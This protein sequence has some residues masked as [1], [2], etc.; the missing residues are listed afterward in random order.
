M[1]S[2]YNAFFLLFQKESEFFSCKGWGNSYKEYSL[3]LSSKGWTRG[4]WSDCGGCCVGHSHGP[5][6]ESASL[7][8]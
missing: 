8:K 3:Y 6:E 7:K 1:I 5:G 2:I 4:G